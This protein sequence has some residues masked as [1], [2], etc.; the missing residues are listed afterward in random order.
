MDRL[1]FFL[2]KDFHLFNASG[3]PVFGEKK[4]SVQADWSQ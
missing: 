1:I 2:P 4:N 3:E